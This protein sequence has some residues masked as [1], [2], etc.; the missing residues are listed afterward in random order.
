MSLHLLNNG[1]YEAEILCHAGGRVVSY[2]KSDGVN[3]LNSDPGQWDRIPDSPERWL[4]RDF[5]AYNGHINWVGPQA[6]WWQHQKIDPELKKIRAVWPPDPWLIYGQNKV[7]EKS[8]NHIVLQGPDS[9]VSGIRVR[10]NISLGPDGRIRLEAE[11]QNIRSEPVSCDLWF[12]TRFPGDNRCFVPVST[13]GLMNVENGGGQ[14][15]QPMPYVIK[16]GFFSFISQPPAA[17]R[18]IRWSKAFITPRLPWMAVFNRSECMIIHFRIYNPSLVHSE[19]GM[20]EVYN[21]IPHNTQDALLEMEY[22]TPYQQLMPEDKISGWEEWELVPYSGSDDF[23]SQLTALKDW[24]QRPL[25][26]FAAPT[27]CDPSYSLNI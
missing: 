19:Q 26:D 11:G 22:H 3:M 16:E 25:R 14:S 1:P 7:L 4:G 8:Q 10:K 20:V 27:Q 21:G 24:E 5:R 23:E 12:N 17:D 15:E 2:R 13:D 18:K 6:A 9:P